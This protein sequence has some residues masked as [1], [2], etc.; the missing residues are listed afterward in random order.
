MEVNRQPDPESLET[1]KREM[2]IRVEDVR[3]VLDELESL[4]TGF[5]RGMVD[6]GRIGMFGHSLGGATT[7][8]AMHD[9]PRIRAGVD[10]D[11]ALGTR[12]VPWGSVTTEGL[13]R[14]FLLFAA[15]PSDQE[16]E[17]VVEFWRNLRGWRRCL[18]VRSAAHN[19]FNDLAVIAPQL[20]AAGVLGPEETTLL[21]G[22]D[23]VADPPSDAAA[24]R[25]Y[26]RSFFDLHLLGADDGMLAGPSPQW[27]QIRFTG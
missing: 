18:Q 21:V 17:L 4:G 8:Q 20:R 9:D 6:I 23:D 1:F 19:T 2:G 25:T 13:D 10:L 22:T 15:E 27:P 24:V 3:F 16:H 5:G 11:G 26:L 14:P 12:E 7:A